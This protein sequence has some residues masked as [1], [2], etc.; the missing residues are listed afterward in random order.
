[1]IAALIILSFLGA[2][3]ECVKSNRDEPV[4]MIKDSGKSHF[5]YLLKGEDK[6][7]DKLVQG[8]NAGKLS[9]V[10]GC[11]KIGPS[12]RYNVDRDRIWLKC[13]HILSD[14]KRVVSATVGIYYYYDDSVSLPACK[15]SRDIIMKDGKIK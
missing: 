12:R 9:R 14:P 4:V 7:C 2:T 6:L 13:A 5:I 8:F 11:K 15:K 3:A 10:C 1:M